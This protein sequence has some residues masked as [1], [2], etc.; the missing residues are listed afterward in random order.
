MPDEMD[1]RRAQRKLI[2]AGR[3]AR[4]TC[5]PDMP[6]VLFLT[7]PARVNDPADIAARLPRGWGV[8]YRH[9]GAPDREAQAAQL[10]TVCSQRGLWLLIGND[11]E[12]AMQCRADGVHWAARQARR[13]RQW[14]GRFRLMTAAA[15][16]RETLARLVHLPI[17]A[18]LVSTVFPSASPS[19]GEA[20]GPLRLRGLTHR[21][22][23]AGLAVYALGGVS[24]EN[25]SRVADAA[26]IAA[27]G[28]IIDAFGKTAAE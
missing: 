11:P 16:A 14:Q 21:A 27:I 19:A 17:D 5:G 10:R 12:L 20:I 23:E 26:G 22:R 9:F 18:A 28:G 4:R 1:R 24:A 3:H 13:A 8:V 6:P 7:D 2:T 15:H 25:A